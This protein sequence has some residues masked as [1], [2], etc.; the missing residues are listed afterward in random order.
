VAI[1]GRLMKGRDA[2]THASRLIDPL[3]KVVQVTANA[4]LAR[5]AKVLL[6]Q[7]KKQGEK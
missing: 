1:A 7:A 4:D 5:R 2:A 3:E 6:R